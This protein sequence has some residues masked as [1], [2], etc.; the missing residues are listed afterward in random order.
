VADREDVREGGAKRVVSV[1]VHVEHS[2]E[3]GVDQAD[4]LGDGIPP[5]CGCEERGGQRGGPVDGRVE[6]AG[7]HGPTKP[8]E[9]KERAADRVVAVLE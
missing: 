3:D 5:M 7:R 1:G 8:M 2:V 9:D 6:P 4:H